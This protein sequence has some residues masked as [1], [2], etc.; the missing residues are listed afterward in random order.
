MKRRWKWLG[1]TLGVLALAAAA[2]FTWGGHL[3]KRFDD[4]LAAL[5]A[6]GTLQ[7]WADLR[8][9]DGSAEGNGWAVLD[10]AADLLQGVEQ[11][12]RE[13]ED[14][15]ALSELPPLWIAE[16]PWTA[17]QQADAE[18][19]IEQLRPYFQRIDE[20]SGY[21]VLAA[22]WTGPFDGSDFMMIMRPVQ[23]LYLRTRVHPAETPACV[24]TAMAL[25]THWQPRGP[26]D[27]IVLGV[28]WK[29]TLELVRDGLADGNVQPSDAQAWPDAW[30]GAENRLLALLEKA[31]PLRRATLLAVV[32]AWRRGEDPLARARAGLAGLGAVIESGNDESASGFG[33]GILQLSASAQP[34]WYVS[35]WGRPRLQ[36]EALDLLDTWEATPP[37]AWDL[38][39]LRAALTQ[40][41]P[42]GEQSSVM[43]AL[44]VLR[45][46][47]VSLAVRGAIDR[48][49]GSPLDLRVG[50]AARLG[51][52]HLQDALGDEL[53]VMEAR[54]GV[55]VI[56]P[57]PSP[58]LNTLDAA[59]ATE[60][61]AVREARL[62]DDVLLW[63]V[64]AP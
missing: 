39:A 37:Q 4:R 44:A 10:K 1:G 58:S 25:L 56:H 21:R 64:P 40:P 59:Y 15:E 61:G 31:E 51:G 52:Q 36:E 49:M 29:V 53:F 13:G 46:A 11:A 47:R 50:V 32:Q 3:S 5:R 17:E 45:L 14:E 41:K 28:L 63:S 12:R 16:E 54:D 57:R 60:T 20:A 9:A 43:H 24:G 34:P 8:A 30:V 6:A 23:M 38:T 18:R 42:T 2:W 7:T 35:W 33:S 27:L 19:Y 26:V 22:P 55:V 62:R 48:G